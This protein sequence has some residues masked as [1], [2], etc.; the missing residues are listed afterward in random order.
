M[1]H[2]AKQ[3]ALPK[4]KLGGYY[5]SCVKFVVIILAVAHVVFYR[6]HSSFTSHQP[7]TA[8]KQM[9]TEQNITTVAYAI[10][11]IKCGDKQSTPEGLTDAALV[12][13]HSVHL[14]SRRNPSSGSKYDYK[15]YALVHPQA[16]NCSRVLQDV[17]F[18]I[19]TVP[20]PLQP[21]DIRDEYLKENI[22]KEWCCGHGEFIKLHAFLLPEPIVVHVDIDFAFF[23]PMDDLYDALLYDASSP[24][25]QAAR[26]RIP[27]EKT[28]TNDETPAI[29]HE[30]QAF[31]TRDWPQVRPG[32]LPGYQAGFLVARRNPQVHEEIVRVIREANYTPG[33][34]YDCG[35]GG[36]G[37][38]VFVGAMAMQ[39]IMAYY[40]DVIRP[41]TAVELNQCRFNW[42]GMDVRYNAQ[43]NFNPRHPKRGE[44]RNNG[45]YCEDCRK[46]P[47]EQIY[48]VHYT[49]CRKPWNCI[50]VGYPGG[51]LPNREGEGPSAIDTNAGNL[52]KPSLL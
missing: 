29:P 41:N 27:M 40:Y 42:M 49:Q 2:L 30:I 11:L 36:L 24:I 17:G 8:L 14:Q 32:R 35:W 26:S 37:Y 10:S 12:L 28:G 18:T 52:G 23:K 19:V 45:D 4:R 48:N 46:T 25:G 39:G 51:Y 20:P 47:V 7:H 38:G 22:H 13:R 33:Y 21:S 9:Q 5:G 34:G 43:P 15:M 31:V 6:K 16:Q 1:R 50:S 44:C 3:S